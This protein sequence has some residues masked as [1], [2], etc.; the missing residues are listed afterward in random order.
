MTVT[1]LQNP[2]T[3]KTEWGREYPTRVNPVTSAPTYVYAAAGTATVML[4][5]MFGVA[6]ATITG[7]VLAPRQSGGSE[8]LSASVSGTNNA[9]MAEAATVQTFQNPADSTSETTPTK[10]VSHT[11]A[12]QP[13]ST[14]SEAKISHKPFVRHTSTTDL[15]TE[16]ASAANTPDAPTKAAL[17]S[18][19]EARALDD[20]PRPVSFMIEGDVTVADYDATAGTIE[21]HEGKTFSISA[22]AGNGSVAAWQDSSVNVHYRCDQGGN[23]T[24]FHGGVVV[25]NAR[26]TI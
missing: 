15:D 25:P 13:R 21:T 17:D 1:Y 20:A 16:T 5:L 14:N 26:L 6:I 8:T 9:P 18:V 2:K 4:G 23:C 12:A 24:L 19:N 7:G 3:A 11:A 10:E 22:A